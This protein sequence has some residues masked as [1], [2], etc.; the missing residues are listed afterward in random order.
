MTEKN[1]IEQWAERII[2]REVW[3]CD[4][5]L[6]EDLM[7][8]EVDGFAWDDVANLYPNP[9]EIEWRVWWASWSMPGC[10][11]EFDPVPFPNERE[12]LEYLRDQAE[13]HLDQLV[14]SGELSQED[15]AEQLAMI[16]DV[17][18]KIIGHQIGEYVYEIYE[19]TIDGE[20]LRKARGEMPYWSPSED[21]FETADGCDPESAQEVMQW[22]R[23]DCQLARDLES[24]GEPVLV[25]DYGCWWGRTCFG[26]CLTLDGTFQRVAQLRE[27][28]YREAVQG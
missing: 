21:G 4:S 6:I 12:A 15:A 7:R 16:D 2:D 26:Q 9:D 23:V 11:P 5:S 13:S 22:F 27:K 17:P 18:H 10:L 25:N 3:C 24:I 20:D 28:R 19:D 14:E 8:Q 1:E